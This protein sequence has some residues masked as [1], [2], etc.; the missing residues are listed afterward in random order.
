MVSLSDYGTD[1]EGGLY[2]STSLGRREYAALNKGDAVLHRSSLLHGVEVH[3]V[4]GREDRTE[5]WS[6]IVWFR[7]SA[8]CQDFGHEVGLVRAIAA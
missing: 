3:D 5:R 8:T 2:V 7:D 6:W 1:Y 4:E